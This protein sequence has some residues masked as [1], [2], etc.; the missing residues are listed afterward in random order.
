M[1]NQISTNSVFHESAGFTDLRQKVLRSFRISQ[2]MVNQLAGIHPQIHTFF[3]ALR[4]G[5]F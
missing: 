1:Q 3:S 2:L 4:G 5:V